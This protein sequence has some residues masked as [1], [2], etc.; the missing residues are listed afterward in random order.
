MKNQ[1]FITPKSQGNALVIILIIIA[2]LGAL[3]ITMTRMSSTATDDV[4]QE[5]ASL[6]ADEML[7]YGVTIQTGIQ[8]L[9][10]KGC[11]EKEIR[12]ERPPFDGTDTAY[13]LTTGTPADKSCYVFDANGAG[14]TYVTPDDVALKGTSGVSASKAKQY[15]FSGFDCMRDVGT[16][17]SNCA[18]SGGNTDTELLMLV[19]DIKDSVCDAINKK[20]GAT[21]TNLLASAN[22][23]YSPGVGY[24]GT[25][26]TSSLSGSVPAPPNNQAMCYYDEHS[27]GFN[28]FVFVLMAR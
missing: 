2:L 15:F 3:T 7:R 23:W 26:G 21:K 6:L 13:R 12:F 25:F 17:G 5:Q 14:L 24:K 8:N 4:S 28:A 16:G 9:L 19:A 1:G 10:I 27:P 11:S 22:N 18:F 20:T